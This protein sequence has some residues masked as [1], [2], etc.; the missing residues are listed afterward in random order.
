VVLVGSLLLKFQDSV[1][2]PSLRDKQSKENA[3][4]GGCMTVR[5]QYQWLL[6]GRNG[7]WQTDK[8]VG[9]LKRAVTE[10]CG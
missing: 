8:S 7:L 10:S 3:R 4:V 1:L 6:D 9:A 5:G 2:V